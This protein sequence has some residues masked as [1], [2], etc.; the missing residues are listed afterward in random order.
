[1]RSTASGGMFGFWRMAIGHLPIE[2]GVEHRL[3]RAAV[4]VE[5]RAD[6]HRDDQDRNE[7]AALFA[8][9]EHGRWRVEDIDEVFPDG[10]ARSG[11]GIDLL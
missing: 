6:Q 2:L 11:N 8:P 4:Q 7:H 10:S 5:D 1:M 3:Q 9:K